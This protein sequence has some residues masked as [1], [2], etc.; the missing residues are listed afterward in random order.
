MD[1]EQAVEEEELRS[2]QRLSSSLTRST[3]MTGEDA[4]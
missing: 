4:T 1:G 2:K 3:D